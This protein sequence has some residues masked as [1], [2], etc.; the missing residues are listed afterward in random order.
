MSQND[1]YLADI[2]RNARKRTY[3]VSTMFLTDILPEPN[4]SFED[5]LQHWAT[6]ENLSFAAVREGQFP[7]YAFSQSSPTGDKNLGGV[8]L[9]DVEAGVKENLK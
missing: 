2:A 4:L 9:S 6:K 3:S 5:R 8:R 1:L 7:G